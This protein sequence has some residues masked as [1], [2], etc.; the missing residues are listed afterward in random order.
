MEI[1]QS[2]IFQSPVVVDFLINCASWMESNF[3]FD[4]TLSKQLYLSVS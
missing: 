3:G 1:E 4:L 2:E